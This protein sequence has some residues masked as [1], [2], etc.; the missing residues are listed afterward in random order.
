MGFINE[1]AARLT[2][3][4]LIAAG[5]CQQRQLRRREIK[6]TRRGTGGMSHSHLPLADGSVQPTA[7]QKMVMIRNAST[8]GLHVASG[9]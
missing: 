2:N 1:T 6:T 9:Y 8:P 7:L 3:V 4:T 5:M